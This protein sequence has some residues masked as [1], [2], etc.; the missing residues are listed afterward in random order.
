MSG[1]GAG[2]TG[3]P[4]SH[5]Q[6]NWAKADHADLLGRKRDLFGAAIAEGFDRLGRLGDAPL[7]KTAD[8]LG[9]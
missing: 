3:L 6:M 8:S 7:P 1:G 2:R 9:G 4:R 5:R